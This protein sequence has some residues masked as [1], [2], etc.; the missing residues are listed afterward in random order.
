VNAVFFQSTFSH[1]LSINFT[2]PD[3]EIFEEMTIYADGVVAAMTRQ[4]APPTSKLSSIK[5][6]YPAYSSKSF[7]KRVKILSDE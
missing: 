4:T 1:I 7:Y 6:I 3:S 5:K 2:R